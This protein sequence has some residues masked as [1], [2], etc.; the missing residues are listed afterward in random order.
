MINTTCELPQI[1]SIVASMLE[2][3]LSLHYCYC[4]Q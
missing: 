4:A 1:V 3:G 2:L